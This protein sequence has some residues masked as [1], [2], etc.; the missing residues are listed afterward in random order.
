M[1]INNK[2]EKVFLS[3]NRNSVEKLYPLKKTDCLK[4]IKSNATEPSDA[5]K[6]KVRKAADGVE[7]IFIRQLLSIMRKTVPD[8][9]SLFGDGTEGE[10]FADMMDN[11]VS[12]KMSERRTFGVSDRLY[13]QMIKEIDIKNLKSQNGK[14]VKN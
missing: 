5:E 14:A 9:S 12:D 10:I 3:L 8:G 11:A 1:N 7:A 4:E 13:K 2:T 6:A